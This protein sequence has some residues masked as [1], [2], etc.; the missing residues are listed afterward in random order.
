MLIRKLADAIRTLLRRR[1]K[2]ESHDPAP[3]IPVNRG[4]VHEE[5]SDLEKRVAKARE[6]LASY[7]TDPDLGP[8]HWITKRQAEYVRILDL[9]L[10]VKREATAGEPPDYRKAA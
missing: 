5:I 3:L 4:A 10:R 6:A 1:R 9:I 7:R 8:S 2:P